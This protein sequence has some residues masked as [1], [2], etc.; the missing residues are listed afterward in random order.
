MRPYTARE[1]EDFNGGPRLDTRTDADLG[2]AVKLTAG[3]GQVSVFSA[4]QV[5]RASE[6]IS[7]FLDLVYQGDP[8]DSN[9]TNVV[10]MIGWGVGQ[11]RQSVEI[12]WHRGTSLIVPVSG[13]TVDAKFEVDPDPIASRSADVL[14]SAVGSFIPHQ[15]PTFANNITRSRYYV[16]RA[17][18]TVRLEVPHFARDFTI[19]LADP[20]A[21]YVPGALTANFVRL[22]AR[23]RGI[24][25]AIPALPLSAPVPWDSAALELT[26]TISATYLVQYGLGF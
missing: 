25:P 21:V 15:Q 10:G 22:G 3:Q 1:L 13:L 5:V 18:A 16:M 24:Y 12:D 14:V 11:A 17:G 6:S 8:S 26:S 23:T 20:A 4:S 2:N 9:L 7:V 19:V